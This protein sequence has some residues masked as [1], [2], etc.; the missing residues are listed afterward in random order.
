MGNLHAV[1][2]TMNLKSEVI[3]EKFR[4]QGCDTISEIFSA[5]EEEFL[6]ILVSGFGKFGIKCNSDVKSKVISLQNCAEAVFIVETEND[7]KIVE[8]LIDSTKS[9]MNIGSYTISSHLRG[10]ELG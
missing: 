3:V 5:W 8:K 7:I 6:D 4:K 9:N 2:V 10:I 1:A